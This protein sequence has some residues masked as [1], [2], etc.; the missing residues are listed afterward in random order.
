M[1]LQ[2]LCFLDL[3]TTGLEPTCHGVIQIAGA[4]EHGE[5]LAP[6][7]FQIMPFDTDYLSIEAAKVNGWTSERLKASKEHK[8][9]LDVK[10]RFTDVLDKHCDKFNPQDKYIFVGWNAKFDAD[11]LRSW[12]HKCGDPYYGSWFWEPVLD[13]RPILMFL[14]PELRPKLPNFKLQTVC[15]ALGLGEQG[16]VHDAAWDIKLTRDIY[17]LLRLEQ[18]GLRTAHED[19]ARIY[20]AQK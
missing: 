10:T 2:K 16:A 6:F 9:P 5:I 12:F 13:L 14:R 19:L 7:N 11:F 17:H 4:I 1:T 18:V 15:N 3:E 8:D 20:E